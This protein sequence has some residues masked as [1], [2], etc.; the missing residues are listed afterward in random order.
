ML[1]KNKNIKIFNKKIV[2]SPFLKEFSHDKKYFVITHGCQSNIRDSEIIKGILEKIGF[3]P[4]ENV[5]ESFIVVINTCAVRE[6]AENKVLG[7]I[8]NLKKY[9]DKII[10][11]TG[12]M[13]MEKGNIAFLKEKYSAIKLFVGTQNFFQLPSLLE[14]YI[15]CHQNIVCV[16]DNNYIYEKLPCVRDYQFKAFV[17]ITYGCD[18]FCTYCIVPYTKGRERSRK[19]ND[20]LDECLN[21]KKLGY[22]EIVLVGQNTNSYSSNLNG[23]KIN[24]ANLLDKIAQIGIPR[25]SFLG[26]HPLDFTI[27]IVDVMNKHSNILPYIHLPLQS[28]DD[29]ILK[30]MSRKYNLK[31][32]L[33]LIS[34]IK[35]K[36]PNI[37]LAT[38][39]IVGFPNE[40]EE[41]FNNTIKVMKKIKFDGAFIFIFSKRTGT[42]ASKMID[43]ISYEE[44]TKRFQNINMV[45]NQIIEK[46]NQKYIG[47]VYD[48][49]VDSVS[50]K[51]K[52][53]LTGRL[54]DN[55]IVN[56]KGNS[57]LIG[58]II[59]VKIK[60][61]HIHYLIG[62]LV[63]KI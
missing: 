31:Q 8:G 47:H 10:V 61:S 60:S 51:N 11:L 14:K 4:C 48:V 43:K 59:P 16:S 54:N 1:R 63:N 30:L 22:K 40:T 42:L 33:D 58:Q 36:N 13:V 37:A 15:K 34:Q 50:K 32:Y 3:L 12:C 5:A 25:I 41:E 29:H 9:K 55:K 27:D 38:D 35:K 62:E 46:K 18:K 52:N 21:L 19:V 23:Q 56:F 26:N 2:V 7:E 49:L 45:V 57:N 44:K 24:F 6:K 39:I 53:F 28:G 20:I 17:Q